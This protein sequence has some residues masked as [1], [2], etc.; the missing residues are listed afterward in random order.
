MWHQHVHVLQWSPHQ[1]LPSAQVFCSHDVD[2]ASAV[3]PSGVGPEHRH[4]GSHA[5]T[6]GAIRCPDCR[7][8]GQ[9]RVRHSQRKCKR[10]YAN[11][12]FNHGSFSSESSFISRPHHL[13]IFLA[14]FSC[15]FFSLI[16]LAASALASC[17]HSRPRKPPPSGVFSSSLSLSLSSSPLAIE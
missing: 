8:P 1:L 4:R 17:V 12:S 7:P 9:L 14:H 5:R 13:L 11:S 15:S 6:Q 2:A 3:H 10:C 16:F